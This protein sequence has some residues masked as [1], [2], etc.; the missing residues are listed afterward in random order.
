MENNNSLNLDEQVQ[1]SMEMIKKRKEEE[2]NKKLFSK[3]K[4]AGEEINY[5]KE[6]NE[7]ERKLQ[8]L[9]E[10][11]KTHRNLD[12]AV[13][14]IQKKKDINIFDKSKIDW[15]KFVDTNNLSKDL[16]YARKDGYLSKKRFIELVNYNIIQH[17][18]EAE[19]KQQHLLALK[20]KKN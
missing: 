5:E 9:K 17:K 3:S 12:E 16:D 2:A 10:K 14:E 13:D 20:L 8:E 6:M 19:R 1:K 4:F 18:K 11:N 15:E 7:K